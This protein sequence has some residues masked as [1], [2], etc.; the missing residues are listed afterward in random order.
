MIGHCGPP[1]RL[2]HARTRAELACAARPIRHG[3]GRRDPRPATRGRGAA[4]NQSAP[5]PDVDRPGVPQRPGQ[6]AAHPAPTSPAGLTT[7]AAALA[8]P[9]R[10]PPLDLPAT[11]PGPTTRHATRAG[12]GAA[13][14]PGE[15]TVVRAAPV[16]LGV[17]RNGRVTAPSGSS[18]TTLGPPR[19]AGGR[20]SRG[21]IQDTFS[22]RDADWSTTPK[23]R[24]IKTYC[25]FG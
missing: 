19:G 16:A 8:C 1:T 25:E 2:P 6:A 11:T 17:G 9:A 3:Q 18:R 7:N 22:V 12:P 5:D 21:P 10:G 24:A 20:H 4:P 13:V 23:D 14:G 15:P